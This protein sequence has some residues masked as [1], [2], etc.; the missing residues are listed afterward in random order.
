[1]S[2]TG[3][4]RIQFESAPK[5]W[6]R[7]WETASSVVRGARRTTFG[8]RGTRPTDEFTRVGATGMSELAGENT[9][10]AALAVEEV[11]PDAERIEEE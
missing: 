3:A 6:S 7:A 4:G 11:N 5:S 2:A 8:G 1:M 9:W 10:K